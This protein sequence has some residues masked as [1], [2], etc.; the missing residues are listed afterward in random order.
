MNVSGIQRKREIS[1][2]L[3][4]DCSKQQREGELGERS[5]GETER[6]EMRESKGGTGR[7]EKEGRKDRW[8]DGD[9]CL[10]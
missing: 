5:G 1:W 8:I 9:I 4:K 3:R 10:A 2:L 6:T 7:M